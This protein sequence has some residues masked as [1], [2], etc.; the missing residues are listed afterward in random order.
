MTLI[1]AVVHDGQVWMGGDS[2]AID[3]DDLTIPRTD[4]VFTTGDWLVGYCES[5]RLG[6]VVRFRLKFA[7]PKGDLVEHLATVVVDELRKQL[8]KNGVA[9]ATEAEESMPGSLLLGIDGRLFSIESDYAVLEH[10]T[11]AAIGCGAPYAL[12][13]LWSTGSAD[14][15]E[16]LMT[17]LLAAERHCTGVSRPFT[18]LTTQEPPCSPHRSGSPPPNAPSR[19]SPRR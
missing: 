16:R 1:A 17:A 10:P 12:G 18:I 13:S 11:Y 8:H 19:P 7:E 15:A 6:Q 9:K 4:K 5:F 2:A 14:P 3:G